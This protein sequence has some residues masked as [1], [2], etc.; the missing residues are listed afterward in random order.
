MLKKINLLIFSILLIFFS[1]I[2][3]N[4]ALENCDY[5]AEWWI[6]QS[7]TKCIED[8]NFWWV[9]P[10]WNS[11]LW[12]WDWVSNLITKWV[13][14]ISKILFVIAI[15]ALIYASYLLVLSG[16]E[17]EKIKKAKDII[18]WTLLWFIWLISAWLIVMLIV[19]LWYFVWN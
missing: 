12:K 1:L 7:L 4:I 11:D 13:E 10:E 3:T 8:W 14:N 15:W 17:E 2:W 18:K 6:T 5:N 19:K 9:I 16:W